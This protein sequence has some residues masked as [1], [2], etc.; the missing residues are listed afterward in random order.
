MLILTSPSCRHS[1][2]RK[3]HRLFGLS[4]SFRPHSVHIKQVGVCVFARSTGRHL[5]VRRAPGPPTGKRGSEVEHTHTHGRT[6]GRT[7]TACLASGARPRSID[8][9]RCPL[10]RRCFMRR[11]R[12]GE[13]FD[14]LPHGAVLLTYPRTDL[15]PRKA[16]CRKIYSQSIRCSDGQS[17]I[18]NHTCSQGPLYS[19]PYTVAVFSN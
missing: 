14:S 5:F 6:D 3:Q 18:R 19:R 1:V 16:Y 7:Q 17:I 13:N 8:S 11:A 9:P 10:C 4:V 12:I 15:S 2:V